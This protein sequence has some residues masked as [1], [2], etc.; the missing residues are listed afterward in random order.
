MGHIVPFSFTNYDIKHNKTRRERRR[1]SILKILASLMPLRGFDG[2]LERNY[3][4][5]WLSSFVR[6]YSEA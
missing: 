2:L 1:G 4:S 3:P 6:A 5:V